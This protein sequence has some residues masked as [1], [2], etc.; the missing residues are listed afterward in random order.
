M[1]E[2]SKLVHADQILVEKDFDGLIQPVDELKDDA[3]VGKYVILTKFL[4]KDFRAGNTYRKTETG[5]ELVNY[6]E[7][8]ALGSFGLVYANSI[9]HDESGTAT[10]YIHWTDPVDTDT[11]FWHHTVLVRRKGPSTPDDPFPQSIDDGEIVGYSSIRNQYK[12][13][14]TPF[15]DTIDGDSVDDSDVI[16]PSTGH[17]EVPIEDQY[18]YRLFAVTRYGVVSAINS[19]F[20]PTLDWETLRD[21]VRRGYGPDVAPLGSIF[22]VHHKHLDIDLNFEVVDYDHSDASPLGKDEHGNWIAHA[23]NEDGTV[24]RSL[25]LMLKD[26]MFRGSF[27]DR[28][29]PYAL[30][31]D[32][33][34]IESKAYYKK[35]PVSE[36]YSPISQTDRGVSPKN[37]WYERNP[38]IIF[39]SDGTTILTNLG[40]NTWHQS[41]TRFWLNSNAEDWWQEFKD[42][43]A[44]KR[45]DP[46]KDPN[47]HYSIFEDYKSTNDIAKYARF[48]IKQG[49]LLGL[50]DDFRNVLAPTN[51]RT[52]ANRLFETSG[53][54]IT[55]DYV[56]LPSFHEL[57]G[58]KNGIGEDSSYPDLREG[59]QFDIYTKKATNTR[60]RLVVSKYNTTP[61]SDRKGGGDPRDELA[62][63]WTRTAHAGYTYQMWMM[64]NEHRQYDPPYVDLGEDGEKERNAFMPAGDS[65]EAASRD[66]R[67]DSFSSGATQ[68]LNNTSPG[69][70]PCVVIA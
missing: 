22:V 41:N 24:F 14:G 2:L 10:V 23:L 53:F 63:F 43:L 48:P 54:G 42:K 29:L 49:F 34:C 47:N 16:D 62:S 9:R 40:R 32:E 3:P 21:L 13:G 56:F 57:F 35:D 66:I 26:V 64:T 18:F 45:D 69:F 30:S 46:T 70:C 65:K 50:P 52:L 7:P 6:H 17:T 27:D 37:H 28:E 33:S 36:T 44:I 67:D 39:S 61:S 60:Q 11:A 68:Y 4:G 25:V 51:V 38:A 58:D 31:T 15:V 5:W 20:K 12:S 59:V 19:G 55:Q 1:K 8:D